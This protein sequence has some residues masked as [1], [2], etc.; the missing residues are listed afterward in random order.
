MMPRIAGASL[1]LLAFTISLVGGLLAGNPATVTLSRGILALFFFFLIG[2]VLGTIAQRVIHE[3]EKQR[4]DE[5]QR[6]HADGADPAESE[7]AQGDSASHPSASV[8]T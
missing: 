5:M 6:L 8:A 2:L 3:Y 1:G 7:P 4:K